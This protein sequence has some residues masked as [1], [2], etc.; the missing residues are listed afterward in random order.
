MKYTGGFLLL[1]YNALLFGSVSPPTEVEMEACHLSAEAKKEL[2]LAATQEPRV[3]K[4]YSEMEPMQQQLDTA[5][6]KRDKLRQTGADAEAIEKLSKEIIGLE[7]QCRER[8]HPLLKS[9]LTE[10][11]FSKVLEMEE[12]HQKKVRARQQARAF[13]GMR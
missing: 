7:R 3:A 11:Q 6:E 5:R 8:S 2:K 9:I 4:V 10:E 13:S 12:N 1:F